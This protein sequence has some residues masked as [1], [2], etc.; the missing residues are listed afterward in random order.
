MKPYYET[1]GGILYHADCRDI[2]EDMPAGSV[3]AVISD[4]PYVGIQRE[5]GLYGDVQWWDLMRPVV[6]YSRKALQTKGSAVFLLQPTTNGAGKMRSWVWDFMSWV[7]REW[8]II[9]DAY[10]WNIAALPTACATTGGLMRMSLKFFVWCG[11][12]DCYR[13]QNA[14]LWDA[15]QQWMMQKTSDRANRVYSPSGANVKRNT[16]NRAALFRGGVTPYNVLPMPGSSSSAG[17]GAYGHPASTPHPLL[18]WWIRYITEKDGIVVDPFGGSGTTA[19]EAEKLKRRWLLVERI[20][21]YC[22][23]AVRRIEKY[24]S[25]KSADNKSHVAEAS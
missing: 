7:C 15:S 3:H 5:Y 12:P 20:E 23:I 1:A 18:N 4:P 9:Q 21:K 14:V 6:R 8:N 24:R 19:I 16:M 22:E 25:E 11:S 13:N 10:W 17:G 2:L